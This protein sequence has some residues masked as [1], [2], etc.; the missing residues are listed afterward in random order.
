[1]GRLSGAVEE[2]K[3]EGK[4]VV[5]KVSGV[6]RKQGR[7]LGEGRGCSP[8]G[9]SW[10]SHS[11][12]SSQ[13][14]ADGLS[15]RRPLIPSTAAA[16]AAPASRRCTA[17]EAAPTVRRTPFWVPAP[18]R[19]RLPQRREAT[20][21]PAAQ[22][23]AD[24][25]QVQARAASACAAP[26]TLEGA[27][28][29]VASPT[30]RHEPPPTIPAVEEVKEVKEP[31]EAKTTPVAD[32][33][34]IADLSVIS[35]E[36]VEVASVM[37]GEPPS[38]DNTLKESPPPPPPLPPADEEEEKKPV[39]KA[40]SLTP[41]PPAAQEATAA[42]PKPVVPPEL[43]DPKEQQ[44]AAVDVAATSSAEE[45]GGTQ[46]ARRGRDGGQRE[47]ASGSS[48]ST[49]AASP[50]DGDSIPSEEDASPQP[51]PQPSPSSGPLL[52]H[53]AT[54]TIDPTVAP[55]SSKAVPLEM[56]SFGS[57]Y[58]FNNR[59]ISI[60]AEVQ[61]RECI[62]KFRAPRALLRQMGALCADPADQEELNEAALRGIEDEGQLLHRLEGQL[63]A[64]PLVSK[65]EFEGHDA[66]N[67]TQVTLLRA[68]ASHQV[69]HRLTSHT[70]LK[71]FQQDFGQPLSTGPLKSVA[72]TS[73]HIIH[74]GLVK[75]LDTLRHFGS[76]KILHPLP[77]HAPEGYPRPGPSS[78]ELRD[79]HEEGSMDVGLRQQPQP[80]HGYLRGGADGR[81]GGT[82]GAPGIVQDLHG[83]ARFEWDG[84]NGTLCSRLTEF[85][86]EQKQ[87]AT[88]CAGKDKRLQFQKQGLAD[89]TKA[90]DDLM[91]DI[92][93][94]IDRYTKDKR[95]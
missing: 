89:A 26:L 24:G 80:V 68:A 22:P 64:P 61:G 32:V 5:K 20:E 54:S 72:A 11:S 86:G 15:D 16:E 46:V 67:L 41:T 45:S 13:T 29:P 42:E 88:G 85:R 58:Y 65:E 50:A 43:P 93:A 33:Q 84:N 4:D 40:P 23:S 53:P 92:E 18:P 52:P 34:L 3:K 30:R 17:V 14:W 19:P 70:A 47:R 76:P 9:G 83:W 39:V 90:H 8:L 31:K 63:K 55:F 74:K 57:S 51:S 75:A 82:R 36:D 25:A 1:M 81:H 27:V 71:P 95:C 94:Y 35:V 21:A 78:P 7:A 10:S 69:A 44:P 77:S 56:H 6:P 91:I 12:S 87:A 48:P 60:A 49:S 59:T 28:L 37:S 62:V 66:L 2:A 73:R 79:Y 38:A